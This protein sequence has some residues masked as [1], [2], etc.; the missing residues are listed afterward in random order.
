VALTSDVLLFLLLLLGVSL[1]FL[2]LFAWAVVSF[3]FPNPSRRYYVKVDLDTVSCKVLFCYL[4]AGR[5]GQSSS[6]LKPSHGS[7]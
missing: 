4:S 3:N 2:L 5:I 1:L 7:S 6:Q